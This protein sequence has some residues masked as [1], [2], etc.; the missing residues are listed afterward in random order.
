M[1]MCRNMPGG[2]GWWVRPVGRSMWWVGLV[3][4]SMHVQKREVVKC[5]V[6]GSGSKGIRV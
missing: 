1:G 4:R 2:W 3:S 6:G 5:F